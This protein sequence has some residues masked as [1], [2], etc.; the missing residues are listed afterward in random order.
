M[1]LFEIPLLSDERGLHDYLT[2]SS[3][4]DTVLEAIPNAKLAGAHVVVVFVITKINA[5][6]LRGMIEMAFALGADG[7]MVNRFNVGGRG[8]DN[9]E[10]LLPTPQQVRDGLA[11]ADELG[12]RFGL[13]MSCS[14]AVP[15]CVVDTK[16]YTHVGFGFCAAGSDRAYCTFDAVGNVRMCNH[17]PTIIGNILRQPWAQIVGG[18]VVREFVAAVPERCRDCRLVR[19]CQGGC[20]AAAEQCYQSLTACDPFLTYSTQ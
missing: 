10:E 2:G 19:Q 8:I 13:P 3:S 9:L 18:P 14:V 7:I 5:D 11:V 4:F 6:R 12:E 15:P 1:T 16:P 17:S 20:K